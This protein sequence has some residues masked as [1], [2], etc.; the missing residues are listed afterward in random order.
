[1]RNHQVLNFSVITGVL[2]G[3][4]GNH[5]TADGGILKA[6]RKMTAS[7]CAFGVEQFHGLVERFFEFR[8]AHTGFDG[9]SLV[10]FAKRDNFVEVRA[11]IQ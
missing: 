7:V 10:I 4:S 11:H 1:M 8:A 9:D 3:T 2:P 6:L 5:P